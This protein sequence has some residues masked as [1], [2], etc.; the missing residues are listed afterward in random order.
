LRIPLCDLA[1]LGANRMIAV[2]GHP[3]HTIAQGF[4]FV[5]HAAIPGNCRVIAPSAPLALGP[6]DTDP[7]RIRSAI[8]AGRQAAETF[9][10]DNS[11]W[12]RHGS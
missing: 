12:I 10:R 7:R 1:S 5:R 8:E 2:C 6:Y 4:P 3:R 11:D 9:C